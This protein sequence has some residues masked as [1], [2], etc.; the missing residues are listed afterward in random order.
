MGERCESLYGRE[1]REPVSKDINAATWN[2][3]TSSTRPRIIRRKGRSTAHE[4]APPG[5]SSHSI[6]RQ[7]FPAP[8]VLADMWYAFTLRLGAIATA[9]PTN[10]IDHFGSRGQWAVQM[11]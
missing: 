9:V 5:P 8:L 6:N 4:R 11:E 10:F 2:S 1:M 7:A 3:S